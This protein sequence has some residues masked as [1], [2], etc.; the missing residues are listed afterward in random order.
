[1]LRILLDSSAD[2]TAAECQAEN[3]EM[4]PLRVTFD[5]QEHLDGVDLSKDDFYARL[6]SSREFPRTSQPSPED[7][8]H[9][10]L[11]AKEHGDEL[12]YLPIS[13]GLS[14]AIQSA[15]IAKDMAEY[16]GVHILD[17]LC[18]TGGI[19]I[20]AQY[21]AKLRKQGLSA[22]PIVEHLTALRGR[23]RLLA[24]LDTLEYLSRGGRI[25]KAI[26]GLGSA[27]HIKP[28]V[29]FHSDGTIALV[30]KPLGKSRA[31]SAILS[32]LSAKPLD[33]EFPL[34]TVYSDG[35]ENVARLEKRLADAGFLPAM[36]TR[37]GA[38]LG[39][40]IGPGAFGLI[41]VEAQ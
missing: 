32:R 6:T 18:A 21:A 3:M 13:S 28:V 5:G 41:Y 16:D 39:A 9:V 35:E 15:Q 26:A 2:L 37:I 24:S 14:G 11:N 34:C 8:L 22:T 36:R 31:V 4:I 23:I 25:S 29:S 7:Y 20:L 40:H 27:L 38:A 12:I 19:R 10:F 30:D 33:P 1:M 17:T